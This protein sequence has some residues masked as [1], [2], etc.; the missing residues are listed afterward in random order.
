MS[1]S[2]RPYPAYDSKYGAPPLSPITPTTRRPSNYGSRRML[3]V[4]LPREASSSFDFSVPSALATPPASPP[5]SSAR[6]IELPVALPRAAFPPV[7]PRS[8]ES[9][10][11][12][13]RGVPVEYVAHKLRSIGPE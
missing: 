13:L 3:S 1:V 4:T 6:K 5:R 10:D 11:P 12:E 2:Q 7:D 8:I 9:L